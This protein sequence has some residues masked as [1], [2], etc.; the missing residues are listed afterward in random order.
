MELKGID[1]TFHALKYHIKVRE[2]LLFVIC[3]TYQGNV[4]QLEKT[5]TAEVKHTGWGLSCMN[6]Y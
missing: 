2:C 4:Y 5:E 1:A 3:F 6:P